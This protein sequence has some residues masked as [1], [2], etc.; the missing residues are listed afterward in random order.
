MTH[1][2]NYN[3]LKLKHIQDCIQHL[4]TLATASVA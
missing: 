3:S 4:N 1:T 2:K